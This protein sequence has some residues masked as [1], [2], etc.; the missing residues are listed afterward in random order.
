MSADAP[1]ERE[2]IAAAIEKV[3]IGDLRR[4]VFLCAGPKCCESAV[5]E[6]VWAQLKK[7]VP[8]LGLNAGVQRTARTRCHCLHVCAG[9]PIALVYPE[10]VWYGN[11][12]SENLERVMQEH[13]LD[14]H[15]VEDLVIARG[16]LEGDDAC[17]EC[18]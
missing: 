6:A 18:E 1:S 12:T 2:K 14:G 5:G 7:R 10:G 16:E 15:V 3:G 4:H 11:M 13:L 17:E 8:E 9:G